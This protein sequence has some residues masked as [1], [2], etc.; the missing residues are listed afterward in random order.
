MSRYINSVYVLFSPIDCICKCGPLTVIAGLPNPCSVLGTICIPDTGLDVTREGLG[1]F[2][3]VS[4]DELYV[5]C[6]SIIFHVKR[7]SHVVGAS[8]LNGERQ[9]RIVCR[10]L[11]STPIV[12][13]HHFIFILLSVKM[14]VRFFKSIVA[15]ST[16]HHVV[17]GVGY[18]PRRAKDIGITYHGVYGFGLS[19]CICC[20]ELW[21]SREHI[22]FHVKRESY[23]IYASGFNGD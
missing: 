18:Y 9:I 23:I 22:I 6:E 10:N 1:L 21:Y 19:S 17:V 20:N 4:L 13:Y 8:S 3:F 14:H 16:F 2:L 15:I 5:G 7:E 11:S 12:V